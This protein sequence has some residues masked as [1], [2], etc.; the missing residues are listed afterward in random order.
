VSHAQFLRIKKL[1]GEAII[2]LAARHNLREIAAEIGGYGDIDG[3]RVHLNYILRGAGTAASV[4]SAAQ[5]LM[6]EAKVKHIRKDAVRGL[7]II[8]SLRAGS[9]IDDKVFFTDALA[10]ADKYFDVPVVSAVAHLDEAAIHC[11]AIL[12]PIVAGRMAGS[13]LMGNKPKLLAMQTDFQ[14]QVGCRYGLTYTPAGRRPGASILPQA[15]KDVLDALKSNTARLNEPAVS[16]AMLVAISHNTDAL[17]FAL[18]LQLPQSASVVKPIG[19]ETP[20]SPAQNEKPIGFDEGADDEKKQSLCSVGFQFPPSNSCP[21][22]PPP[23][24]SNFT[25]VSDEYTQAG[26][27]DETSGEWLQVNPVRVV[28]KKSGR[29]EASRKLAHELHEQGLI[30]TDIAKRLGVSQPRVS[31]LLNE[32][33]PC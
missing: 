32:I 15:C 8:F 12:V 33:A 6:D 17:V 21:S 11:H 1:K 23:A 9:A 13:S 10:W 4:A 22:P 20:P 24:S 16:K 25:R 14:E 29:T 5:Q 26:Y 28:G 31:Q 7:E 2:T 3:R 19:F 18:G 27:W 30:Q